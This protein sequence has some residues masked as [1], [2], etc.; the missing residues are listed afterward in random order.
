MANQTET[1]GVEFTDILGDEYE[2]HVEVTVDGHAAGE[3][4]LDDEDGLWHPSPMLLRDMESLDSVDWGLGLDVAKDAI[5]AAASVF[6][7]R[8][9]RLREQRRR[10]AA[11]SAT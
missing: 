11:A 7:N 1:A 4:Y 9:A 2:Q 10:L 5:A 6:S 3:I 8:C